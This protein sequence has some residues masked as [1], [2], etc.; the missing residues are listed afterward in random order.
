ME[1]GSSTQ[2]CPAELRSG[3]QCPAVPSSCIWAVNQGNPHHSSCSPDVKLTPRNF[4]LSSNVTSICRKRVPTM[5]PAS[6]T[7][8]QPPGDSIVSI[9]IHT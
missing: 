3:Q 9:I 4:V 7:C 1:P 8:R 6:I 5:T 2:Q